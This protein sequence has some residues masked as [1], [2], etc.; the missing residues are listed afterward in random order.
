[1]T[2]TATRMGV[3]T[4]PGDPV[5]EVDSRIDV[6]V[7]GAGPCGLAAAIAVGRD[8]MRATV[9]D[10]GCLVSGIHGYP[11]YMTFFSTAERISIGGVPFTVATEKP[12]R[13]DALAY[14]RTVAR[15]FALDVRQY[16]PVDGFE[17]LAAGASVRVRVRVRSAEAAGGRAGLVPPPTSSI[18]DF[19]GDLA[20]VPPPIV[21]ASRPPRFLVHSQTRTGERRLT[22]AH[23]VVVATGYFGSPN[24][25][26][27][28]GEALPHVTHRFGDG[29]DSW[30]QPVVV[31]GGGNSAVDAALELYRSGARVTLVHFRDT[32]DPNVKPWVMPDITGRIRD[33]SIAAVFGSQ[34]SEITP[35]HVVVRTPAGEARIAAHRVYLM[36][37]YQPNAAL[38]RAAGVPL[39]PTTGI[40]AHDPATMESSVP[41]VFIAG[42]LASGFDANKTFI[43]NGRHHGDLIAHRLAAAAEG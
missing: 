5:V 37:G 39:D 18:P 31:V 24:R 23:A 9:F 20:T 43:E 29:H 15:Y 13:R 1:M 35:E 12:T 28:P 17:R 21:A 4:Q 41:G 42:V 40:P 16:E 22:A 14:Y 34:V 11:T 25:L 6:A 30:A 2:D 33:G 10:R 36:L 19:G 7:I 27:V 8:G 26:G 32:I 38:L 3:E